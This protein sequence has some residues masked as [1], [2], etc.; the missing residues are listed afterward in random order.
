MSC[1]KCWAAP[2]SHCLNGLRTFATCCG[3][4]SQVTTPF[5]GNWPGGIG[6]VQTCGRPAGVCP[7][8]CRRRWCGTA[9][10]ARGQAARS[11]PWCKPSTTGRE[12][13]VA[14]AG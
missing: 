11:K 6:A 3:R 5:K 12:S 4:G 2:S 14:G 8:P 10:V 1:P 7:E 9:K 13:P